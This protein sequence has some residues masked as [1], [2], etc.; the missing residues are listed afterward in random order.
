MVELCLSPPGDSKVL[1]ATR[2]DKGQL[3]QLDWEEALETSGSI[4]N[5]G[6]LLYG[7]GDGDYQAEEG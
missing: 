1:Q 7:K 3:F 4:V 6:V 5:S 2:L